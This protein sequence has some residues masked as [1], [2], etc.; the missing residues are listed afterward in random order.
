MNTE[1][2]AYCECL[3]T[4]REMTSLKKKEEREEMKGLINTVLRRVWLHK[5]Q[6]GKEFE[7]TQRGKQCQVLESADTEQVLKMGHWICH[8]VGQ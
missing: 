1:F 3:Q 4:L 5:S 2:L 7:D 8:L 6:R